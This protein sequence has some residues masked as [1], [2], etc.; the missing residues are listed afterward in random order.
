MT[1]RGQPEA[2][3]DGETLRAL[4]LA[5]ET[6]LLRFARSM[7][8]DFSTA[9]DLVQEAFLRLQPRLGDLERPRPWLFTTVRNLALDHLRARRRQ[10]HLVPAE[11]AEAPA[12]TPSPDG[13]LLAIERA[14]LVRLC[15]ERLPAPR[16]ELLRLKYE[17]GLSYAQIAERQGIKTGY[18]GYQ[19][20]HALRDLE[21]ELSKEGL[22][23]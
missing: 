16:R 14:S 7:V 19:L 5:N 11:S 6:A 15:M 18:V 3:A 8:T 23:R 2:S 21:T 4:F 10:V 1:A 12:E 13:E 22:K 9:Q 17:E 20:H